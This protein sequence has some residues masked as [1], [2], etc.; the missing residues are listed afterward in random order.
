MHVCCVLLDVCRRRAGRT[1]RSRECYHKALTQNSCLWS[2]FVKLSELG[3]DLDCDS[4]FN[5]TNIT[6]P[7][8]VPTTVAFKTPKTVPTGR[9][10]QP[11]I[12]HS[13]AS[14]SSPLATN[15]TSAATAAVA[16]AANNVTPGEMYTPVTE[17]GSTRQE[18]A[19]PMFATTPTTPMVGSFSLAG[20]SA[21][22]PTGSALGS[23]LPFSYATPSPSGT[24]GAAPPMS[25]KAGPP[26]QPRKSARLRGA[27]AAAESPPILRRSGR[28]F[29]SRGGSAA[30]PPPSSLKGAG[31]EPKRKGKIAPQIEQTPGMPGTPAGGGGGGGVAAETPAGPPTRMSNVAHTSIA[32]TLQLLHALGKAILAIAR[33]D[34]EEA[35]SI[36]KALPH[37]QF[38]TGWTQTQIGKAYFEMASDISLYLSR[39]FLFLLTLEDTDGVH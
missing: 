13:V 18:L 8:A 26:P 20:G 28:L 25:E 32:A 27:A 29:T 16:A 31:K 10:K 3:V 34:C 30:K 5:A 24:P 39:L 22:V 35:I 7:A 12:P 15:T 33:Y 2:C 4:I 6:A 38:N 21:L 1:E 23:P 11:L 14:M 9:R 37:Q 17:P 19:V 36:L